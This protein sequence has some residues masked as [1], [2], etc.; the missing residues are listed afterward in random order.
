MNKDKKNKGKTSNQMGNTNASSSSSG[1]TAVDGGQ[2]SGN[3][4]G[5]K[6]GCC[7]LLWVVY[8][9]TKIFVCFLLFRMAI[10]R[11]SHLSLQ[12]PLGPHP[13]FT[14]IFFFLWLCLSLICLLSLVKIEVLFGSDLWSA[15][16]KRILKSSSL[17]LYER[18]YHRNEVEC[19]RWVSN[20]Y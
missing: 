5:D 14:H 3:A 20:Q 17:S 12:F 15:S 19:E 10:I 6:H 11:I 13:L 18:T 2:H 4:N 8:I 7:V 1:K 16:D 9:Y